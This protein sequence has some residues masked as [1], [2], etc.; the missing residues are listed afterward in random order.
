[1]PSC[2]AARPIAERVAHD[3]RPCARPGSRSDSSKRSTGVARDFRTGS[4]RRRMKRHRGHPA[5]LGL[6]IEPERLLLGLADH[7]GLESARPRHGVESN[8]RRDGRVARAASAYCGSTSTAKRAAAWARS[9]ATALHRRAHGVDRRRALGRAHHELRA[10]AALA[11]EQRRRAE[12]RHAGGRDAARAPPSA[13]ASSGPRLRG[14][15]DHPDQV[16]VRRVAEAPR[17]GSSSPA[18]KPSESCSRGEAQR[19]APPGRAPA[20]SRAR[21]ARRGRCGRRAAP[22]ARTCAPRRG[23]RGS[24]ASRR[25][26]APRPA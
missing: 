5:R 26:R 12:H 22:R 6:G 8:A 16:P 25:R 13:A 19:R 10:V 9:A 3:A 21:R 2:G 7:L 14:R 24:A 17:G 1:M 15:A 11:P 23:S 18:R 4:P 20:R